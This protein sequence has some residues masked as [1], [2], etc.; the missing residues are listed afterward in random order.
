VLERGS[1]VHFMAE[2]QKLVDFPPATKLRI[3]GR[4]LTL[5]DTVEFFNLILGVKLT[6]EEE[7]GPGGVHAR[8]VGARYPAHQI[9]ASTPSPPAASTKKA[10]SCPIQKSG[11]ELR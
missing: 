7:E 11:A 4:L 10:R 8:A 2:M 3:D 1:Q 6:A 5:D 9:S